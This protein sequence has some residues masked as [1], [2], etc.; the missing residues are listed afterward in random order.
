MSQSS[1]LDKLFSSGLGAKEIK[2]EIQIYIEHHEKRHDVIIQGLKK[3]VSIA[4]AKAE[5]AI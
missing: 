5:K 3:H 4:K 2:Q 1:F